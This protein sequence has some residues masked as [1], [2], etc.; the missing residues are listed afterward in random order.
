MMCLVTCLGFMC[1][2]KYVS[3]CERQTDG[4]GGV[5]HETEAGDMKRI[6]ILPGPREGV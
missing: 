1:C 3:E 4:G 2:S 6:Q 5:N